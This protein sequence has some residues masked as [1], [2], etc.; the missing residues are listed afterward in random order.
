MKQRLAIA[1]VAACLAASCFDLNTQRWPGPMESSVD[2]LPAGDSLM[3]PPGPEEVTVLRHADPVQVRP[4]GSYAGI[5]MAFYEKKT[6]LTAGGQVIVSPGG[7]AEVLWSQGSSIVLFGRGVGWIG[8]PSRGDPMFDFSDVERARL[9]LSEGDQV[10]LVGGALLSGSSG[11][12]LLQREPAGTLSVHN[13]SKGRLSIAFR[14]ETFELGPGQHVRLPLL[15]A[16]ASPYGQDLGLQRVSGPGFNVMVRGDFEP[17]P[18]ERA[19]HLRAKEGVADREAE[20][21][22]VRVQLSPDEEVRFGGLDVG[23][24]EAPVGDEGSGV[25]ETVPSD[26]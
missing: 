18:D 20:A 25:E 19:V 21:L 15:S 13:Q 9:M 7:R 8:S 5:P 1:L 26:S 3:H 10:R 12:Y 16:G 24:E 17:L 4:V 11:P 2:P 23:A 6:R 14:Q 22:G